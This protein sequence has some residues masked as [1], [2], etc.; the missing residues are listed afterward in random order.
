MSDTAMVIWVIVIW[1]LVLNCCAAGVAAVFHIWYATMRRRVR[2][3]AAAA[4]AA[5]LNGAMFVPVTLTEPMA[6]DSE[7][8]LVL[9]AVFLAVLAIT[10]LVTL[11]GAMVVSSKLAAPGDDFRAFE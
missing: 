2:N 5:L 8:P 11:P 9:G 6:A 4:V 1:I 3:V 7:E 10:F